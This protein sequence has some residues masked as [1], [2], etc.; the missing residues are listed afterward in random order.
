M[1]WSGLNKRRARK[2]GAAS[3]TYDP[4]VMEMLEGRVLMS[5]VA[6]SAASDP[7]LNETE[8]SAS[9]ASFSE[10]QSEGEDDRVEIP[11]ELNE[12]LQSMTRNHSSDFSGGSG[13]GSS[14]YATSIAFGDVD[15]DGRDEVGVTRKASVNGR[16]FIFDDANAGYALLH[17]GGAGW[18]SGFYA[19]DIAFGDV[20]GDGRDE[21]G[22]TRKAS[23][24]GRFFI[25][26]DALSGFFNLHSG[27][28][29]WGSGFHATAIAFGDVDGDGRDE[30]GVTRQASTNGRFFILEDEFSGFSTIHSGGSGWGSG[31]YAT[32]IAFG[33]VDGDGR[34]EVGVT[35]KASVNGRFFILEDELS[36]FSTLHSG[37]SGWGSGFYATG[38]AFGDVD[39]DGRDEI[40]VSRK[41]SVNGRFFILEDEFSGFGTI[42]SGGSGWGS[43]YYATGIAFGDVDG[44]GRDE[45]GVS[46]LAGGNGRY[47]IVEDELA[48]FQTIHSGGAGWG[49]SFYATAIAF[50]DVD[51]D[52]RDEGGVSR[53]A[54][55]NGRFFIFEDEFG[56][57]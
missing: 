3:S 45:I 32:D 43:G 6:L 5:S 27:G 8:V 37:G 25:L 52:G 44:D 42:H 51:G 23:V 20:D 53:K 55:V 15:G 46:R 14:F 35:R 13:W 26:E 56:G 30:V 48:S 2:L 7:I 41:A 19:T 18:G 31:F 24:N 9:V 10:P 54:S 11:A 36:G 49:S 4:M 40:G 47:F 34:D 22:V 50:G 17:S 33:D 16:F 28:S 57:F 38:I 12:V 29:G 39:G 1:L 21:V